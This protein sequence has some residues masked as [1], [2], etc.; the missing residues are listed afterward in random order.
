MNPT[1]SQ[2]ELSL[3]NSIFWL[4]LL[5]MRLPLL[6]LIF[7]YSISI[8]GMVLVP[9][10]IIDGEPY[11]MDFFHAVYFV[12][13]VSTT[14]GFGE[15]PETFSE[16]QRFWSIF[17]M[18]IGVIAWLYSIGS[19]LTLIQDADFKQLLRERAFTREVN[20]IKQP[21]YLICGYGEAGSAMTKTLATYS[22]PTVV[23]DKDQEQ[24]N[25]L[26]LHEQKYKMHVPG[27]CAD[28]NKAK[29]LL[30]AGLCHPLCSKVI[31]LTSSDSTNLHVAI[32]SKLLNPQLKVV[33]RSNNQTVTENMESFGT[34]FIFDPFNI[35][36]RQLV[37][38]IHTPGRYLI[39]KW[40]TGISKS[41]FI[42]PAVIPPRGLWIICGYGRFGK[43]LNS[44]LKKQNLE[45]VIIEPNPV[46]D[47]LP[48]NL[49]KGNGTL[50]PHLLS[51]RI[52]DAVGIVA[53]SNNDSNNLSIL[54]SAKELNR[55]IYT[56]ARQNKEANRSLFDAFNP[57]IVMHPA[58]VLATNIGCLLTSPMLAKFL[59]H[60]NTVPDVDIGNIIQRLEEMI[61]NSIVPDIWTI[62]IMDK[63]TP[64]VMT[65][66]NEKQDIHIR[67]LTR[68]A[69]KHED[70]LD[71]CALLLKR[72][73]EF[74]I[75]P[76][77][78]FSIKSGDKLLFC[79]INNS[80]RR[81]QTILNDKHLLFEIL[82]NNRFMRSYVLRK[83]FQQA[84]PF[85]A[86]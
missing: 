23:V 48:D 2:Q 21:F 59:Y 6:V 70:K 76:E 7:T 15:I 66:I 84:S 50:P 72:D 20:K 33:C 79:G 63:D 82:S 65:A 81:M 58:K 31:A 39:F 29:Y 64:S 24:I 10:N 85:D 3:D 69:F 83:L 61:N 35:F 28:V 54:M 67:H 49:I 73:N 51:A 56:V 11:H 17:V 46:G 41:T 77:D 34:D 25:E 26:S 8:L 47:N 42:K 27:L 68:Q 44:H 74:T 19:I 52:A 75:L 36:A 18:Y 30:E 86:V 62:N 80:Y 9:G 57:N 13:Y 55:D 1:D 22:I 53:G 14:I 12:S 60:I 37:M 32:S 45:T 5:R 43:I 40:L 4:I 78:S 71:C 38:A 16:L